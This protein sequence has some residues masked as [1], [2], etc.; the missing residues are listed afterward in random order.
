MN[1]RDHAPHAAARHELVAWAFYDWGHS[2]FS[3]LI[4]T[5]VFA[6]YF[7]QAVVGDAT[8]GTGLWGNVTAMTGL[9]IALAGPVLGALADQGGRRK[10]WIVAFTLAAVLA[11]GLLW[12]VR[13]QTEDIP[14]AMLL[15]GVGIIGTEC[16]FVF[17]NAMLP[18]LAR[19][20]RIGRWSGWGWG[21]GYAGGM[22]CLLIGLFGFVGEDPWFSLDREGALHVRATFVLTAVWLL[23]FA[24]PLF[25]F[26]PD[27]VGER[28][29]W[30]AALSAGAQQ[31]RESVRQVRRY[32]PIL[33]FLIARMIF[34]DGLATAFAFGGVYAAGSFDM[35]A[36]QVLMFGIAL[37]VTAGLG[38]FG[39]A[40]V[41]DR[42]GSRTTILLSLV[43]LIVCSAAILIVT[44]QLS[45][46]IAGMTLG[47]FVGPVQAASRSWL[48]QAAPE[49]LR[50][51][52]F[53]LFAL[54]G[55][56]TAF[57]GPLLV[58][59]VTVAADS[60]RAGMATIVVFFIVGALL[61]LSVP[62][63]S[64][65]HAEVTDASPAA[66]ASSAS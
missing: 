64:R 50:T 47:I 44:T 55:K 4:Q 65:A 56:A 1:H 30:R 57:L 14:L 23:V 58:G 60:Q 16:A 29:P 21:L 22:T 10:P 46:W 35:S 33:R 66:A 41:D 43:G 13:P 7:T 42:A 20:E 49:E 40:W 62:N 24:V 54:S 51:Q 3:A 5:F 19:P 37:N 53:G 59:W 31:L 34:A 36:E 12:F 61:M 25:V 48:S 11:T 15:A 17:Y 9:A 39:F 27:R 28:R 2:A 6:A 8:R 45:F 63:A 18:D 26:T 52:M 38:A 32:L